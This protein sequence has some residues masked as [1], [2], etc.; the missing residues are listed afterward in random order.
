MVLVNKISLYYKNISY[1]M[2]KFSTLKV[3][4]PNTQRKVS[5]RNVFSNARI[6]LIKNRITRHLTEDVQETKLRTKTPKTKLFL[7]IPSPE[8]R[9]KLLHC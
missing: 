8:R 6:I 2:L 5:R 4:Q 9:E 7:A 3:Q 1:K